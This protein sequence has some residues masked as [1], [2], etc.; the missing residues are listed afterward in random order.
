MIANQSILID[1]SS[2]MVMAGFAGDEVPKE[3]VHSFL[4][5]F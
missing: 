2:G 1:N 3:R 4:N 5:N